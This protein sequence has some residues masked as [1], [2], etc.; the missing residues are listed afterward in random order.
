VFQR[1]LENEKITHRMGKIFAN[2]VS[3]KGLISNIYKELLEFN[4]KRTNNWA[5]GM[6]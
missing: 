5:R 2:H 3:S 4:N 1:T 6:A